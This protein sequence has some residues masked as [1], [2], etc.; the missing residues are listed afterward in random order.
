VPGQRFAKARE[1]LFKARD[2]RLVDPESSSRKLDA[3]DTYF[4]R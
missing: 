3:Y 4:R 2:S 1:E